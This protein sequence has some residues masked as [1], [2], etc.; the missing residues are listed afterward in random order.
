M[1]FR[2]HVE[3]RGLGGIGGIG[4]GRVLECGWSLYHY[5]VSWVAVVE[6]VELM[7]ILVDTVDVG[8]CWFWN[9]LLL[10]LELYC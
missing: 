3:W 10:I 8:N 2:V 9:Y 7:L 4:Y 6:E 1:L 5:L